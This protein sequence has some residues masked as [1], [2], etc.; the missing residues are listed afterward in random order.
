MKLVEETKG[1]IFV[2]SFVRLWMMRKQVHPSRNLL[3]Q[4]VDKFVFQIAV[5]HHTRIFGHGSN[6]QYFMIFN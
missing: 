5:N 2:G 3:A 6:R 4:L 1:D